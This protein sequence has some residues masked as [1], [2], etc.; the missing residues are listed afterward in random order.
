MLLLISIIAI[1]DIQPSGK[2]VDF[3]AQWPNGRGKKGPS[4]VFGPGTFFGANRVTMQHP[5]EDIV[6]D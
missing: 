1:Q 2:V 6:P 4:H 5:D 3:R